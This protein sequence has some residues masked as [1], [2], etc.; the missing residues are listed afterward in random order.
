MGGKQSFSK[1]RPNCIKSLYNHQR[2]SGAQKRRGTFAYIATPYC[3]FT[4][5]QYSFSAEGACQKFKKWRARARARARLFSRLRNFAG[6]LARVSLSEA[7]RLRFCRF[8]KEDGRKTTGR[9]KATSWSQFSK[10]R[11]EEVEKKR[12]RRA[13]P[14]HEG[15]GASAQSSLEKIQDKSPA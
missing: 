12:K 8:P 2:R 15:G 4:H 11:K 7:T 14:S 5:F 9:G 3:D 1:L 10:H 13:S 6:G